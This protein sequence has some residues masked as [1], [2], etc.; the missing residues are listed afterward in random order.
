MKSFR[1][2]SA[3]IFWLSILTAVCLLG[4]AAS[5]GNSLWS[6]KIKFP[7]RPCLWQL[8]PKIEVPA[9]NELTACVLLRLKINAKWTGFVYKK[10]GGRDIE[11]GL[12]GTSRMVLV[13]LFGKEKHFNKE[14]KSDKWYSFCVTWSG[15][16]HRLRLYIDGEKEPEVLL[17]PPSSLHLAPNG[18]LTLGASHFVSNGKV[19]LENGKD[20]IGDIGRFRIW[21][22]EWSTDEMKG[23]SCADGDVV[24]WDLRQWHYN[25]P[26]E[27][28]SSLH[29]AWSQYKIQMLAFMDHS[30]R[31][32]KCPL[33]L[34][35]VT[36]DWLENVFPHNMSVRDIF[37]SSPSRSHC[38]V[39]DS[40]ALHAQQPQ[41][42]WAFS[43]C[44]KCFSSKIYVNVNP[45]ANVDVVQE[46]IAALLTASFSYNFFNL[47]ADPSSISVLPVESF[48]P[49]ANPTLTA[50]T[51]K[52]TGQTQILPTRPSNMSTTGGPLDLNETTFLQ[53]VF[54]RINL[55]LNMTGSPTNPEEDI[56]RWIKEQLEVKNAM[57]VLNLIIEE[58][59][60][61]YMEPHNG[62]MIFHDQQTQ[63]NCTFQ[64]QEYDTGNVN[65][66]MS[67]INAALTSIYE[68]ESFTLQTTRVVIKHI[69]PG[70]CPDDVTDT[71]Y[72]EYYWSATCPQRSTEIICEK[73]DSERATRFCMLDSKTDKSIWA[74]PDMTA[75]E[76]I[77]TISD[78]ENVNVTTD[79]AGEV[80]DIIQDLVDNQLGNSTELS[81]SDLDTIVEK[82]GEVVDVGV[83]KPAVGAD[84]VNIV[85]DILLSKTNI[86]TVAGT[87]LNLTERMG[88][89]MDFQEES[90]SVTAPSLALSMVNVKP[91]NFSGLTFGVSFFSPLL[92]PEVSVNQSFE[93][94]P[95]TDT[96]AA[97][98]LP[99]SLH[100][101][102]P[103]GGTQR[104]RIQFQFYGT[105]EL[106]QEPSINI[107]EEGIWEL[108]SYIVS[109]SVNGSHVSG[110][111]DKVVV[112]LKHQTPITLK[113][114]V[115]CVFW[116]FQ[117]NAGKGGWDK[118]G[119]TTENLSS[120]RTS[121]QCDHL[122]HFAVLLDIS[123]GNLSKTDEEVLMVISYLGCGISSIF[124][125]I[126]L[127][128]YLAFEKLRR[129]YPSKILIN[130]IIALLGLSMLFLL[131]SWLS[132]FQNY[133]L[134]IATAV[135]LH[136]FLLASVT[137]MG[138]EALHMYLAL[139][140]V[141]NIY[142][143]SYI[144]K[145]CAVGWGI[146]LVIVSLV[147]A[148]DKDA[149]GSI[150]PEETKVGLQSSDQ[151]CWLQ[152]DVYFYVTVAAFF[153]L[154]ML[155]NIAVF[156][157]V[158]IQIR[159]MTVNKPSAKG[160]TS[161]QDL[162]AVA[163]ITVLLGLTWSM[164]FFA[165]GP[166]RVAML[167]L[168][169]IFN[170]LQ[171]FFIFVFHCL[172]KENVRKQ[173]RI[174]LCCGRF[175]LNDYSDWSRSV[176]AGG[177]PGKRSILVN[178]DSSDT[179]TRKVSDTSTGSAPNHQQRV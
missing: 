66:T 35:E 118:K 170:S 74:A 151:F 42:S 91:G 177:G 131:D 72:G 65:D 50:S 138:L 130:L 117:K 88:N 19:Q 49:E 75:C 4:S 80:V 141:F 162:R 81:P 52:P 95:P 107:G 134:C 57:T 106:F 109:A 61:R 133:G 144:L 92:N 5:D 153:L 102:F 84:I 78:L 62:L 125:G 174:H 51:V 90:L 26:P 73:P 15:R 127:L 152:D 28:D 99:P 68:N 167:Y 113:T 165:I 150:V 64:V 63:Y 116:D 55:T 97:I 9:L 47:T 71:I 25:C 82:L 11:L 54:F 120:N 27:D 3:L 104:T 121:C 173:W 83:V 142:I 58:D 160:R 96:D 89:N 53:D 98:S 67:V 93:G 32:G 24:S 115:A 39:N 17:D 132:S 129:D 155:C 108:N 10:P 46:S 157:V 136:Y 161:L 79:N 77:V 94:K 14:L 172:L 122:T 163:S 103:P 143:P 164:G 158:L 37:V 179:T 140:K 154:I 22:R 43:S 16:A 169:C 12:Q 119:C 1:N 145:F 171:G 101:H 21:N 123:R 76:P 38:G 20:L 111:S 166:G 178:S 56:E 13:W 135:F 30:Q 159:Q 69:M 23:E 8:H 29:C 70:D 60:G 175:R 18:S 148:I 2:V 105:Q 139:V 33:S 44:D 137:W 110:L 34:E 36:R 48:P 156:I 40:A 149:Y 147:L 86:S 85:S 87:V 41:E 45:A 7:G 112:T 146:P 59:N 168:F 128:T 6:K 124:L 100:Q 31:A 126:T 176:T 114:D